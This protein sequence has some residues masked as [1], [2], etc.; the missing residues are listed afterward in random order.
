MP[1]SQGWPVTGLGTLGFGQFSAALDINV[2][3]TVV[4]Y[5]AYDLSGDVHAFRWNQGSGMLDIGT[6]AAP[7]TLGFYQSV[8]F[9]VNDLGEVVGW[10]DAYH[11]FLLNRAFY[12]SA[13]TGMVELPSDTLHM[14]YAHDIT[15]GSVVIGCGVLPGKVRSQILR[16]DKSAVGGWQVTGLGEPAAAGGQA[17]GLGLNGAGSVVGSYPGPGVLTGFFR[18]PSGGYVTLG[19]GTK[20][21]RVVASRFVGYGGQTLPGGVTDPGA[22]LP[23][24]W[25]NLTAGPYSL[26][27][28]YLPG[29]EAS[30]LNAGNHIVGT[31][32]GSPSLTYPPYSRAFYWD[33][34]GG[35]VD[36]GSLFD[37]SFDAASAAA[38]NAGDIVAGTSNGFAVIWGVTPSATSVVPLPY[39][40]RC[41]DPPT[42]IFGAGR[43][44]QSGLL[45]RPGFDATLLDPNTV[46][47]SDGF[48]HVTPIAHRLKPPGPP[49]FQLRDI[50]GDGVLDM[51]VQFSTTEMINAG[52]L[53]RQSFQFVVSWIDPTGLPGSGKYPARVR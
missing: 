23:W 30:D 40:P 11:G 29:G 32:A 41:I 14:S 13:A 45:S 20:A 50:N 17:C 48:G 6:L 21:N 18:K 36:L 31:V 53:T 26:G 47:V 43:F 51:Q 38:I 22:G 3:S 42:V 16:W 33:C 35:M 4:G 44:L 37:Q 34:A 49:T 15:N 27:Y 8:A 52:T 12:W 10:S 39:Q 9:G 28:L 25:P 7:G 5:S 19:A 2:T 24:E 1:T 46:T